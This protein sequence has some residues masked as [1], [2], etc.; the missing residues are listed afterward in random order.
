VRLESFQEGLDPGMQ[1]GFPILYSPSAI[2][3]VFGL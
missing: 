3:A 2:V 1:S